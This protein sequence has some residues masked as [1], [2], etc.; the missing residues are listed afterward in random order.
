MKIIN[1]ILTLILITLAF[2]G[3]IGTEDQSSPYDSSTISI[4][5]S[6]VKYAHV[7]DIEIGYREFGSGEP[8]LIIMPFAS[9]MDMC[10]VTFIEHL[11][12]SYRVILFDN[13]GMGYS[14]ENNG[15]FSIALFANDTA[16]LMD[17]L[18]LDSAHI[19][20]SSM[21][22]VIAQELA[23]EHPEKVDWLILSST[24]YSLDVP[25]TEILKNRLQ[26]RASDPDTD[27]VLRKYAEG[28]LEWS[29]TYERLPEIQNKVL[30]LAGN[31]DVLTPSEL[32]ME[33]TEQ[34]PDAHLVQFED[35]GHLGEQY[36]P[37]EYA[38]TIVYFLGFE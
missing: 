7:N 11:A 4:N 27:P 37:E 2:S 14:S 30:L 34:V 28:N 15:S 26:Y 1:V 24:T 17:A 23:L 22:S 36:L 32:S 18:G 20:G 13:R 10:N 5:S 9:T 35:V 19:F 25:Q 8:L 31:K 33:I 38:D 3:C 29:G 21:G 6:P 16:D 12:G